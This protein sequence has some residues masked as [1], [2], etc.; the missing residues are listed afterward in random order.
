MIIGGDRETV[1]E[2]IKA[3][4]AA[5]DFYRKVETGDPDP[6]RERRREIVETFCERRHGTRY[7]FRSMV[8]RSS[9]SLIASELNR[10]TEIIGMEKLDGLR[11]GAFITSNHFSPIEN[12]AV[13]MMTRALHGRLHIVTQVSNLEMPG[14]LGFLMNYADTVP[15]FDDPHYLE[16]EFITILGEIIKKQ[17]YVLIYPEQEMWFH[18]R[19]PRPPKRGAYYFASQLSAPVIS[20][21]VEQL[22]SGRPESRA[23]FNKVN[24]RLHVLGVLRPDEN[25][26]VRENSKILCEQDYRLKTEAYERVYGRPLSYSFDPDDIA[27]WRNHR[28]EA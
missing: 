3:A 17:G 19:K 8:A 6:S 1:I 27:G 4:E 18:Y 13:R 26:S 22:D 21:F 24:F 25:L 23:G 9:A 10:E 28:H 5:G 15:I 14:F 12:T 7:K 11:G 16:G 2:N 20:C